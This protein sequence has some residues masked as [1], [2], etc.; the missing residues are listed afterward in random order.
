MI[1]VSWDVYFVYVKIFKYE[2]SKCKL[3]LPWVQ[4]SCHG[5]DDSRV[6]IG[7]SEAASLAGLLF[8]V[9]AR[10][11]RALQIQVSWNVVS[12][13][14]KGVCSQGVLR[15]AAVSLGCRVVLFGPESTIVEAS[16]ATQLV[17]HVHFIAA[18]GSG[19]LVSSLNIYSFL[20]A[21]CSKKIL[22]WTSIGTT[23]ITHFFWGV[24]D[25]WGVM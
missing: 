19:L 17:I 12:Y 22:I 23:F 7:S 6:Q 3:N 21:V 4:W 2:L 18:V 16:E 1:L 5:A 13:Y 20:G 25:L 14:W 8:S 11:L 9:G 10:S 15:W 24:L